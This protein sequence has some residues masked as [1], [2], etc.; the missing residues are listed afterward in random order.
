MAISRRAFLH[1]SAAAAAFT[2]MP[3]GT[4]AK[5][6]SR[7]Q[8]V[9]EVI[10]EHAATSPS[11]DL[12][13][14]RIAARHAF[15][16][17]APTAG[18]FEGMLLGNG[19]IGLCVTVRP[20]GMGL[21]IGK[22]DCWDIRV[23]KA[24]YSQ[25]MTNSELLKLWQVASDEAKRM[26]HPDMIDLQNQI[27]LLR[28][29][30][31]FS[32]ASYAKPW[33][34]PWPCGSVWIH[35]D[36]RLVRL[37]QQTLDPSNGLLTVDLILGD[38]RRTPSREVTATGPFQAQETSLRL[39]CFVDWNSGLI[40]VT[41]DHPAPITSVAYYP[42]Y[43]KSALLPAPVL[44]A[45]A[46]KQFS[47][48]SC[49][50]RLPNTPPSA[51]GDEPPPSPEDR[52]FA[53]QGRIAGSWA[54][55]RPD[56]IA[57]RAPWLEAGV[58]HT[59]FA[60]SAPQPFR[61]DLLVMTS[62][63]HG[64]YKARVVREVAQSA[65]R[66][67][68]EIQKESAVEWKGFWSRS[69]VELQ[70]AELEKIWYHNQYFLACCLRN[71][72]M[73]PGQAGNWNSRTV[74]TSWHGD[75]HFDYNA[76]QLYWGVFSSNHADQH[77]PYIDLIE[78]LLP[79]AELWASEKF[80]LPGA[81]F[82][83][84]AYPVPNTDNANPDIP[85]FFLM[86]DTPWAVQSLWWHYRYTMD[87]DILKRVYPTL[88]A[89]ARFIAA[90]AKKGADGKYHISPTVSP[91]NYGLTADFRLN[92]DCI[93]DLALSRF[94]FNAVVEGSRTLNVDEQERHQWSDIIAN[95]ASYPQANGP[96]GEVW[97]DVADGPTEWIFNTPNT[98]APVF[99]GEQVGIGLFPES[100]SIARRTAET[101]RLEGGN[102]LV[103]QPLFRAR[104]G[105]L[106]LDWFKSEVR[107]CLMPN[108]IANDRVR[109][110][111]G[112]YN[113]Q[114][115]FDFMMR[116][117][118]WVE[119]FSLPAVLNECMLQSYTGT[120]RLFPNSD[121]L[122]PARFQ[123]LRAMGAFLV[124][125]SWDGK[126]VSPVLLLSEK[127]SVARLANPWVHSRCR[128][129]RLKDKA[130][131]QIRTEGN[132]IIFDTRPGERYQIQP[133]VGAVLFNGEGE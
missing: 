82:P 126:T 65:G 52:N 124:S 27:P 41:S 90:Y 79:A 100:L 14:V 94:L 88:R 38:S 25:L 87:E 63:D 71:G 108:G 67:A 17:D 30:L 116:M 21:H 68:S 117:S 81:C 40:S 8:V 32:R 36:A 61:L 1:T 127:G 44:A 50:Q 33:P 106:N 97:V 125:A 4:V 22:S 18:F 37:K 7:A 96:F 34:H 129:I 10:Q 92:R 91:E 3:E 77:F 20:D 29:Y 66:P 130:G 95:L 85:W 26:G 6:Q 19:D 122:G 46:D 112:R 31:Q 42:N 59:W 56:P 107:Y 35:W 2:A 101:I 72:K 53:L 103:F 110:I 43:D 55:P 9:P 23:S 73:A 47:E 89:A 24:N 115:D 28:D 60:S 121:S 51:D 15:V 49:N 11:D 128:V 74:G 120:I 131:I 48:F 84:S 132:V 64:D 99:P 83:L 133:L 111:G 113:D 12:D 114:R 93:V 39:S 62:R 98:I 80:G 86:S 76:E 119:N 102:D 78:H 54:I 58:P 57:T 105:I 69:A 70:D 104:L 13:P 75:F 118:V 109:E 16:R 45:R 5:G 123:D